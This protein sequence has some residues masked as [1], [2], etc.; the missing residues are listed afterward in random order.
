MSSAETSRRSLVNCGR[1]PLGNGYSWLTAFNRKAKHDQF[2]RLELVN[3]I[4]EDRAVLLQLSVRPNGSALRLG[5]ELVSDISN[6][7][8]PP[9]YVVIFTSIRFPE[10]EGYSE[11]AQRMM[12]LAFQQQGFLGAESVR[13]ESGLGITVSYWKSLDAISAWKQ[14]A[15]HLEAQWKARKWYK[16]YKIRIAKVERK[17]ESP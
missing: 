6:T 16:T 7:P 2:L 3:L 14:Q 12:Q 5:D 15:E 10:D 8:R 13:G 4:E 17:S 11:T 9:Y 1:Q